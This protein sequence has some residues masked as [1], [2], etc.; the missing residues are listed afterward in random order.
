MAHIC[1]TPRY[2]VLL[3]DIRVL[4]V[5]EKSVPYCNELDMQLKHLLAGQINPYDYRNEKCC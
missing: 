3:L 1:W 4:N 5:I 2:Y